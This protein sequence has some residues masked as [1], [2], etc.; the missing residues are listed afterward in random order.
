MQAE[1]S[2]E[3]STSRAVDP[4]NWLSNPLD[5][6]PIDRVTLLALLVMLVPVLCGSGLAL[7]MIFAPEYVHFALA[8]PLLVLYGMHFL[9]LTGFLLAARSRRQQVDDWPLY[10]AFVCA[11]FMVTV[12][13]TGFLTGTHFGESLL[14]NFLGILIVSAL[15]TIRRLIITFYFGCALLAVFALSD[16]MEVV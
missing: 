7:V 15:G 10:E 4:I 12:F 8:R 9:L 16:M 6:R 14:F 5:W 2:V 1:R 13:I 11:S 3:L